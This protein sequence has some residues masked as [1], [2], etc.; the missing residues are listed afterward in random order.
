MDTPPLIE[1]LRAV[2]P[3]ASID[4]LNPGDMPAIAVNR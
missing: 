3:G 2:V 4:P 1:L